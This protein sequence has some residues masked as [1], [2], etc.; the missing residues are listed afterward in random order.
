MGRKPPPRP[1]PEEKEGFWK[2]LARDGLIALIIVAAILG[3][4]YA[5]SGNWP[6]LVVVES[7]SMQHSDRESSIGVIDTGDMVFQQAASS[8]GSVITYLEGRAG[9]YQTYGDFGDVIIFRRPGNPT[10][11]IH[12]AIMYI[13][14]RAN[15]TADVPDIAA[16]PAADWDARNATGPT[17]DPVGMTS[18]TIRRAGFQ[19]D[20]NLTFD[21]GNF[22][23][24]TGRVGYL[25][26]GDHN[27]FLQCQ[28]RRDD[29]GSGYDTAWL[30]RLED[31]QGRARGEM[32]WFGL[33][34]LT[35]APT[36]A[37]C[38]GGWG[39]PEAPKN[40]WDSL[41]VS[42]IGLLALPFLIEYAG[43]GWM[44][45]VAPKLPPI[46]WPWRRRP[47]T[48][49][50]EAGTERPDGTPETTEDDSPEDPPTEGSSGP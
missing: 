44:K 11:V 28:L 42:L 47:A 32:P 12:R 2:G 5:Y 38:A 45:Y 40:S 25:T 19:H 18:L 17:R 16:L 3:G 1:E 43:R 37:C 49:S 4:M 6:P 9:G 26:M 34:K 14:L 39:D 7:S 23:F 21:F 13:T 27:L 22:G 33:I 35:L 46:P 29:C 31:V 8:R 48:S 41:A 50:E 15:G 36:D 30:P 24:G 20:I 10:P